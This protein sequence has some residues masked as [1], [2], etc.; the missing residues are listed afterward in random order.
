MTRLKLISALV[1]LVALLSCIS[2]ARAETI[3]SWGDQRFDGRDFIGANF[4]AVAAGSYH[5]LALKSDGSI[6]GWGYDGSGRATPPAGNDYVAI[7]AGYV[8]SLCLKV[9]RLYRGL[10]GRWRGAD[11]VAT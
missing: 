4:Q 7:A 9:R 8:H 6:V 1:C 3:L 11:W 10:G 5:G 2:P